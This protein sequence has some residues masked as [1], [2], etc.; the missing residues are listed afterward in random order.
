MGKICL[1]RDLKEGTS[2]KITFELVAEK[3]RRNQDTGRVF[4]EEETSICEGERAQC[5]HVT[6]GE[7]SNG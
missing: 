2:E 1:D 6:K 4:Q 5:V 3:I 7:G